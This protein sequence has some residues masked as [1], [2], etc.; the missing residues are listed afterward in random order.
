M[1]LLSPHIE[2]L[3]FTNFKVLNEAVELLLGVFVLVPFPRDPHSD[4]ARHISDA[5]HPDMPVQLCVN[6][7]ILRGGRKSNS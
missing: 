3:V 1:D 5:F 7:N 2:L 4:L 6:A